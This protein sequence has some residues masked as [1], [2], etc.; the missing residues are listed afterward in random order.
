M[1]A[2]LHAAIDTP[3]LAW[4]PLLLPVGFAN[5]PSG[6]GRLDLAVLVP[7]GVVAL[8]IVAV[9]RGRL[10][11]TPPNGVEAVGRQPLAHE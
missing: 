6:E 1:T 11:W 9:T 4:L 5:S 3:Q 10:G 2:L 8:L 7:F